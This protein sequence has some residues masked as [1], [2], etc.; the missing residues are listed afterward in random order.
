[1]PYGFSPNGDWLLVG[2]RAV[3]KKVPV[4]GGPAVT[5]AD[6]LTGGV[7]WGPG[8]V[9]VAGSTN[10]L[11]AGSAAG[12]DLS[13]L[14]APAAGDN[15]EFI[16][17]RFL[18]N[19]RAVLFHILNDSMDAAQVAVYDFETKQHRVLLPGASPQFATSG[20]LIFYRSG[21]LWAVPFDPDSLN[22]R[23]EPR[24]VL[25]RV[26]ANQRGLAYYR[27]ARNGT[28]VYRAEGV[29]ERVALR[30]L[31]WVDREGREQPLPEPPANYDW[32][33]VSPDGRSV[34]VTIHDVNTDVWILEL[35]RGTSSRLTTRIGSDRQALWTQ[36]SG[37]VV[38]WSGREGRPGTLFQKRA[39][40]TG[41]VDRIITG[42]GPSGI[43]PASWSP[44]GRIVFAY[45]ST[46]GDSDIGVVATEGQE[47]W[48]PLVQT[49]ANETRPA[50]SPG[51]EWIA[52]TSDETGQPEVY[53]ARFPEFDDKRPLSRA[54]GSHPSWSHDGRELFYIEGDRRMMSVSVDRSSGI[55]LGTPE[56][57]FEGPY[58][59][60]VIPTT[61]I[62]MAIAS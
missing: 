11:W 52:F 16:V 32:P 56:F 40:G 28:L 22:V 61:C 8:D 51:S 25:E 36:D 17:P 12:G 26:G 48:E 4:E 6:D 1:M 42:G 41:S 10:G 53:V 43:S 24:A 59:F 54:G 38:F 30:T 23:G 58:L 2:D 7:A 18:P 9:I 62:P 34:A 3:L 49:E 39:D 13:R 27:L 35:A 37:R 5:I 14:V 50:V 31:V 57:L 45:Q 46:D 47:G 44:E 15:G 19:G 60:A 33:R 20:H 29:L 21:S 55:T